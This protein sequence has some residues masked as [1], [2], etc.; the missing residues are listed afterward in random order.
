MRSFLTCFCSIFPKADPMN[1]AINTNY[2]LKENCCLMLRKCNSF[3]LTKRNWLL[4]EYIM[5]LL[6]NPYII[7]KEKQCI[8]SISKVDPPNIDYTP[9]FRGKSSSSLLFD[10]SKISTPRKIRTRERCIVCRGVKTSNIFGEWP[11][12]L[13]F[14]SWD[15]NVYIYTYTYTHK[16]CREGR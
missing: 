12:D 4:V 6:L 13:K 1:H 10:F 5:L 16:K 2:F 15:Q 7:T 14:Y 8:S 11:S 3:L 9:I